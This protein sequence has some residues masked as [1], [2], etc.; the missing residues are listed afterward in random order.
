MFAWAGQAQA[1]GLQ[2][3]PISL[4]LQPGQ[5]TATLAVTSNALTAAMVQIRPFS[6]SQS[7][8]A[9]KLDPTDQLSVSPP[10][11]QIEP[12]QTQTF[13]LVLRRPVDNAE[14]SYRVLL[15]QLPPPSAPGS[16]RVAIR[17][18][19]PVFVLPPTRVSA[20]LRWRALAEGSGITIMAVNGGSR[21]GKI[22]NLKVVGPDRHQ[23]ATSSDQ[24]P[25][26]LPGAERTWRTQGA[27]RLKVGDLVQILA[28]TDTG[29]VAETVRVDAR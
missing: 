18:S 1:Q 27:G 4:E 26:M 9:D 3:E 16:V 25:Y 19:L 23:Y 29:V 8:G 13:R 5:M 21:H 22:T 24:L 17:L 14:A 11:T 10:I 15:D 28:N 7:K 2:V 12:G 6:W 20:L